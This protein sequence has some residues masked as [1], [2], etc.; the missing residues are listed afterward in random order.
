LKKSTRAAPLDSHLQTGQDKVHGF[1]WGKDLEEPI[2][3]QQNESMERRNMN[4][5]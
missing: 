2:T 3:G 5:F 1:F 4:V